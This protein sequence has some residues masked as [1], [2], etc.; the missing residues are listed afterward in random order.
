MV[1]HVAQRLLV[2]LAVQLSKMLRQLNA[3]RTDALTVLTVAATRDAT[4]FHQRIE[5][6]RAR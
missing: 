1:E 6:L 5:A 4:L 2:D 3:F